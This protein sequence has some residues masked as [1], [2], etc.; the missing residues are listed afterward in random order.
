MSNRGCINDPDVFCY[1][2]GSFTV[3]KQRQKISA[4]VTGKYTGNK[5]H[6]TGAITLIDLAKVLLPH[7]HKKAIF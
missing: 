2:C 4:F 1:I 3:V 6:Y 5:E 7:L